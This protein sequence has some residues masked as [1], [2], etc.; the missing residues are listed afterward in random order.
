MYWIS[1]RSPPRNRPNAYYFCIDTVPLTQELVYEPFCNDF[2]PLNLAMTHKFCVELDKLMKN[3]AYEKYKIYHYASLA[4]AK[5]ANAAYLMGAFQVIM[6]GRSASEAWAPFTTLSPFP[7]FRDASFGGCSYSCT[8]QH[9][10]GGIETAMRLGWF[11]PQSFNV[12]EYEFYER[13]ENGDFNWIVPG[14]LLAFSSPS[15]TPT[16]A[17]GFRAFTPEDYVPLFRRLGVTAVVRLNKKTYEAGRFTS[18]GMNHYDLYFLDG[19]V[20]AEDIVLRFLSITESE[21][22]AV[23]IHCKAGLGRTGTLIACYCMKHYSFPPAEFIG[24]IRI[25]RPGSILGPQQSYIV[26]MSSKCVQ[27]GED[28][29]KQRSHVRKV[30][31]DREEPKMDMSPVDSLKAV[32]GDQGQAERLVSAKKL[33]QSPGS[34]K[35]TPVKSSPTQPRAHSIGPSSPSPPKGKVR[36]PSGGGPGPT[37]PFMAK[38]GNR[39]PKA[40]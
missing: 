37:N 21:R 26:S 35:N 6:L 14:K 20:P 29:R 22:G 1:D 16:D 3:P 13:V 32:N 19:S 7:A 11:H 27:W 4:P 38:P 10:L 8:I 9:C 25:C 17:E 24:W 18:L 40:S 15:P 36:N 12:A 33:N 23:A 34:G 2:G 30:S 31:F 39:G 5:R 28:V